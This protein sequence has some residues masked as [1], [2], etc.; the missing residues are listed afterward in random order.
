ML[1]T[2]VYDFSSIHLLITYM[3]ADPLSQMA[4]NSGKSDIQGTLFTTA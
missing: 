4:I 1:I 3:G 2:D